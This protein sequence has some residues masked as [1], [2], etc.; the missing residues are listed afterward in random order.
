MKI[1]KKFNYDTLNNHHFLYEQSKQTA[2][3]EETT[4][5]AP[6]RIEEPEIMVHNFHRV[7]H[8]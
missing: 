8:S 1:I 7:N 4:W 2:I 6:W 5:F 3:L